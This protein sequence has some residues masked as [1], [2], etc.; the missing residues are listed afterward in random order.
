MINKTLSEIIATIKTN[1]SKIQEHHKD[2]ISE[3]KILNLQNTI[4]GFKVSR[5]DLSNQALNRYSVEES[6]GGTR[7]IKHFMKGTTDFD[8]LQAEIGMLF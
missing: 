1:Q 2:T 8:V 6:F 3:C 5:Y 7:T 4:S